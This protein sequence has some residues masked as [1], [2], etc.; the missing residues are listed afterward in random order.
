[1]AAH[2][3][4]GSRAEIMI[5]TRIDRHVRTATEQVPTVL[6][7]GSTKSNNKFL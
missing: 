7:Q 5:Y 4:T 3:A 1:V 2:V 6:Q